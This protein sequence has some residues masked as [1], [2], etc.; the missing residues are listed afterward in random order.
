M[1]IVLSK[2]RD[3]PTPFGGL[4]IMCT[5]DHAQ[6]SP[7]KGLSFFLSSHIMTCFTMVIL[8]NSVRYHQ[9]EYFQTLQYISRMNP[10]IIKDDEVRKED[11]FQLGRSV[12]IFVN[13]WKILQ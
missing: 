7:V 4:L 10:L 5:M 13:S 12:L 6:L 8:I 9:D 3:L 2:L 11:F 1:N